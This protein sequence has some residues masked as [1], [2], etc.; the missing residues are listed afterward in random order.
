MKTV[1]IPITLAAT[2]AMV[3]CNTTTGQKAAIGAGGAAAAGVSYEAYNKK[4]LD[5][6]RDRFE[7][8]EITREQYEER[9][10]EIE[11]RSVVY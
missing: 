8:G 5:D 1:I 2:M 9:K 7:R 3:G 6:N 11:S 4:R 10:E